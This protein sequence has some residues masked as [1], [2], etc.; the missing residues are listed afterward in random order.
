MALTTLYRIALKYYNELDYP[1]SVGL[2][3][4]DLREDF[5][6]LDRILAFFGLRRPPFPPEFRAAL[7]LPKMRKKDLDV[8]TKWFLT[9]MAVL[10]N[11]GFPYL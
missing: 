3:R 7:A 9:E 5:L 4:F 1:R 11:P 10:V 6:G 8:K 2:L